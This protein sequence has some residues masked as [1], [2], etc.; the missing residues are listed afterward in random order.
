MNSINM[1]SDNDALNS[2][3]VL[4]TDWNQLLA[5]NQSARQQQKPYNLKS[6]VFLEMTQLLL[7]AI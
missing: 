3:V 5:L 6:C 2:D 4:S 1:F 7:H